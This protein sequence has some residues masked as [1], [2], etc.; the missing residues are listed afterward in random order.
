MNEKPLC[1]CCLSIECFKNVSDE[2]VVGD[3]KEIYGEMLLNTFN[4]NVLNSSNNFSLIC[5]NCIVKLRN[6]TEFKVQVLKAQE[7]IFKEWNGTLKHNGSLKIE[8]NDSDDCGEKVNENF[9]NSDFILDD[10]TPRPS[11][12]LFTIKL[13]PNSDEATN[14]SHKNKT[15]NVLKNVPDVSNIKQRVLR[16]KLTKT[17]EKTSKSVTRAKNVKKVNAAKKLTKAFKTSV[18]STEDRSYESP[19]ITQP[20]IKARENTLKLIQNSNLCLFRSLKTKFGCFMC[21]ASFVEAAKLREHSTIHKNTTLLAHRLFLSERSRKI[22]VY[23]N[24]GMVLRTGYILLPRLC[25]RVKYSANDS[26]E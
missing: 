25:R 7:N 21:K 13:E 14:E 10:E 2:Y 9:N 15:V 6:A 3:R 20:E 17:G 18:A 12:Q 22:K 8:L 5:E 24:Y 16:S 4:I 26:Y 11:D 1:R 23:L 19:P